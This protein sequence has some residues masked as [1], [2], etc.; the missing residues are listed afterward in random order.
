ML[1]ETAATKDADDTRRTNVLQPMPAP[2]PAP[3]PVPVRPSRRA[4]RRAAPPPRREPK[5]RRR[6]GAFTRF[7]AL[8]FLFLLI[9]TVV[10]AIVIV[11][12]G[13]GGTQDFERVVGQEVQDQIDGIRK[14]IED[15]AGGSGG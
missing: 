13:N 5:P 7:M 3:A 15:A 9:A 4:A 11:N 6:R 1:L 14:L 10:A 2:S 8:M 12:L